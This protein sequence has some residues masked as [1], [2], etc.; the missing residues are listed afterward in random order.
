MIV[1][2]FGNYIER[3]TNKLL[4][5][6]MV[7]S[8]NTKFIIGVILIL[9]TLII[10]FTWVYGFFLLGTIGVFGGVMVGENLDN[11]FDSIFYYFKKD[12][13]INEWKK[14]ADR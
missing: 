12:K 11:F 3:Y 4:N 2:K 8:R 10:S 5:K 13:Y 7:M 14:P 6:S 9:V 1:L